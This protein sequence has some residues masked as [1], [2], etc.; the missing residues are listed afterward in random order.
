MAIPEILVTTIGFSFAKALF[1]YWLKDDPAV[2]I[3]GEDLLELVRDK[4]K[5]ILAARKG[6]RF[7][8]EIGDKVAVRL[9][10]LFRFYQEQPQGIG[11]KQIA[12]EAVAKEISVTIEKA[13]ISARLLTKLN[14]EPT[15]LYKH[16][17]TSR[18]SAAKDLS[19]NE[20]DL[21][22]RALNLAAQYFVDLAS[23]L[24]EYTLSNFTEI[25]E[26]I[27]QSAEKLDKILEELDNLSE[28]S[29]KQRRQFVDFERDYRAAVVRKF[30]RINLFGARISRSTKRY[31]LSVAYV[32]L[33]VVTDQ[34]YSLEEID[35]VKRTVEDALSNSTRCT[36][37]GEAGSGKTTLLQWLAVKS[38]SNSFNRAMLDWKDT[39]P[40][41]IELRKYDAGLPNPNE[42]VET[43]FPEISGE[44]PKRWVQ[45]QMKMGRAL[46]LV[47]GL[48]EVTPARRQKVHEWVE[49]LIGAYPKMRTVVTSR[50]ASLDLD[51]FREMEFDDFRLVPM[52]FN[53][54]SQFIHYWHNAVLTE[55]G[56]EPKN[57]VNFIVE[58]LES[59]IRFSTPLSRL[60]TNPLLCAMICAL[61]YEGDMTLPS[62]RIALYESCCSMLLEWRD[63]EKEVH[64]DQFPPLKYA[65]K[66]AFID[67][68][69]YWMMKNGLTSVTRKEAKQRIAQRIP[70]M[71]FT[72]DVDTNVIT[73]ML[74]ERS[75]IIRQ[76]TVNSIDFVHRTFQEY[77]SACAAHAE[78]D[79]GLLARNSIDPMW[80]ETIILAAGLANKQ[81]ADMVVSEIL[82]KADSDSIT[83]HTR[84]Y[85]ELLAISCLETVVEISSSVRANVE[86]RLRKILP[87]RNTEQIHALVAAGDLAVKYL[88]AKPEFSDEENVACIKVLGRIRT[89]PAIK[90]LGSFVPNRRTKVLR[91]IDATLGEIKPEDV[92][93]AGLSR[94]LIDNLEKFVRDREIKLSGNFIVALSNEPPERIR[95]KVPAYITSVVIFQAP[96]SCE[97]LPQ[98]FPAATSIKLSGRFLPDDLYLFSTMKEFA[99]LE[100]KNESSIWPR[101]RTAPFHKLQLLVI[102]SASDE[103]P[104][105]E[106]KNFP[107]LRALHIRAIDLRDFPDELENITQFSSLRHLRMAIK[108]GGVPDLSPLGDLPGLETLEIATKS[109]NFPY[110]LYGIE[111]LSKLKK[112]KIIVDKFTNR[113]MPLVD[114]LKVG[115]DTCIIEVERNSLYYRL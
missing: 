6:V 33:D 76:P 2:D 93:Y 50:P 21:Y 10:P 38:A 98:W 11:E 68:L 91:A 29:E 32:S 37:A 56:L 52:D 5:D 96:S 59:D 35:D 101:F 13:H 64:H 62:E 75:G 3:I 73:T 12:V 45:E 8:E 70:N 53:E 82:K 18:P 54:I 14:N 7:F 109:E 1:N 61:N 42:F 74:I 106:P 100:L 4:T 16:M 31:K 90:K 28:V 107:A 63:I 72:S 57:K 78:N 110:E 67:D 48:D 99:L 65:Q 19:Q 20:T 97:C 40:F 25:L 112:L 79:W 24:P 34:N 102:D 77:M 46:L 115:L 87:P 49:N 55:P 85:L 69:A 92:S 88:G 22:D 26:R 23:G 111:D 41:L 27:D 86:A 81:T 83:P 17:L 9:E 30:D 95:D 43:V 39:V 58:K 51:L 105:F 84:S 113:V 108:N 104:D 44:M 89:V 94:D 15:K 66:R 60:A 71:Q 114:D 80:R 47:D 103:W 36:I